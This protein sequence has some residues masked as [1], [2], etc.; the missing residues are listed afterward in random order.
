MTQRAVF[1]LSGPEVYQDSVV[2]TE[3]GLRVGRSRRNDLV[4]DLK[5]ISKHHLRLGW[6]NGKLLAEDLDSTNGTYINDQRLTPHYPHPVNPGDV[7]RIGMCYFILT[8]ISDEPAASAHADEQWEM[9]MYVSH[10]SEAIDQAQQRD[11]D[12]PE[13]SKYRRLGVPTLKEG[14]TWLQYLP[15]I[16]SDPAFADPINGAGN[17][18]MARYLLI[19]EALMATTNAQLDNLDLYLSPEI[20]SEEWLDWLAGWFDILLL[21]Q[22]PDERKKR[23]VSELFDTE[24]AGEIRPGLAARRGTRVGLE[25]LLTL[26]FETAPEIIEN[27]DERGKEQAYHFTV[28]LP[29][30][31]VNETI[32]DKNAQEVVE[33]LIESYKPAFTTFTLKLV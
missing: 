4:L 29:A 10:P 23:I 7:I 2:V 8:E 22:L 27:R 5:Q 11:P 15:A 12:Y 25:K 30:R 3:S 13:D 6:E 16:Y 26:Y 28:R 1:Q 14:S 31:A 18:F 19:F 17:D 21:P 33:R 32:G 9:L 24:V 20:A